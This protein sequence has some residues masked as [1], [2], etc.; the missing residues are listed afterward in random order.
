MQPRA[1]HPDSYG[2]NTFTRTRIL[3]AVPFTKSFQMN[4]EML[5]WENGEADFAA[6]TYWYGFEGAF[7]ECK[8]MEIEASATLY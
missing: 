8:G 7:D 3:D 2:Y 6:T 5:G 1:D 4:L